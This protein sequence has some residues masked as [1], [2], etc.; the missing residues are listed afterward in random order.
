MTEKYKIYIPEEMRSRL[1]N[2]A[3][4]FEFFKKDHSVNL[5][6]FLKELLINYFEQYRKEKEHLLESIISDLM[7]L[8]SIST[9]DANA[10]ADRIVN[11]YMKRTEDKSSR[12]TAITLTASGHSL[13]V[14]RSIE[15]NMLSRISL[16]QYVNDLFG[17]YLSLSRK[18]RERVIF[19]DTFAELENAIRNNSI[20]TFSST[21]APNLVFTIRPYLI[22]ASKE[23]QC[24][25]LLCTDNI[26]EFP[27][28][29]RISR[30]RALYATSEKFD[31]SEDILK[32]LQETAIR[33][34]QSASNAVT[35]EV[36]LTDHGIQKYHTITKNR[37]DLLRR[38]GNTFYFHWPKKPLEEY[39]KHFGKDALIVTPGE[40]RN[41]M[42]AFYKKAMEAYRCL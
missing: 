29:F 36:R 31:P 4:L 34:P 7:D 30:I 35:A 6:A 40:C 8:S 12:N 1:L 41:S 2:D 26:K 3:E 33:S 20:I 9:A 13:E 28:T 38:D 42:E 16:S 11:S 32:Y 17:S 21:T 39:F 23:E 19:R 5:N 14:M 27:R 24:N 15:N 25:Y 22:A 18:D 37:P 10:I